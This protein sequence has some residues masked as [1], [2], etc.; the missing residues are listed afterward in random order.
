MR[1]NMVATIIIGAVIVISVGVFGVRTYRIGETFQSGQQ[2]YTESAIML[3]ESLQQSIYRLMQRG[4]N[5]TAE[6]DAGELWW[7]NAATPPDL[8]EVNRS[9]T[10]LANE[11]LTSLLETLERAGVSASEP[12]IVFDFEDD[13]ASL[14][15]DTVTFNITEFI[16][17]IEDEESTQSR[18]LARTYTYSYRTWE[19]LKGLDAW[20]RTDAGELSRELDRVLNEGKSCL[21]DSCCCFGS[22]QEPNAQELINPN[23]ASPAQINA[24]VQH[25]IDRLNDL[26][27]EGIT[28]RATHTLSP[29]YAVRQHTVAGVC[30]TPWAS[31]CAVRA[32]DNPTVL[33]TAS[34]PYAS[35]CADRRVIDP[36]ITND[37][38]N[39]ISSDS[40]NLDSSSSG[41]GGS[42]VVYNRYAVDKQLSGEIEVRCTDERASVYIDGD[43]RALE[44]VIRLG[45]AVHSEC[46]I[47]AS[48]GSTHN[49]GDSVCTVEGGASGG[50]AE[51]IECT[52][53]CEPLPSQDFCDA[54]GRIWTGVCDSNGEWTG[55]C[56]WRSCNELDCTA[57]VQCCDD[58]I[59][60]RGISCFDDVCQP[61]ESE[62]QTCED[63]YRDNYDEDE[64]DENGIPLICIPEPE[65]PAPDPNGN[66]NNGDNGQ[67]GGN[68]ENGDGP[69][70]QD[71]G[72]D[73]DPE[74][75]PAPNPPPCTINNPSADDCVPPQGVWD[76]NCYGTASC[77]DNQCFFEAIN[78]GQS[79]GD[80][81]T[82]C[83]NFVC[84]DRRCVATDIQTTTTQCGP[85][86]PSGGGL[87]KKLIYR[88]TSSGTCQ[89]EPVADPEGTCPTSSSGCECECV[90]ENPRYI[91]SCQDGFCGET[92]SGTCMEHSGTCDIS[93]A[94]AGL[95]CCSSTICGSGEICCDSTWCA[96]S[97]QCGS[98]PVGQD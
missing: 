3:E 12:V 69:G 66:G 46:S 76:S 88:C 18:N 80:G 55:D 53:M 90:N 67:N 61:I 87:C 38:T 33:M 17:R 95:V 98:D 1:G 86:N 85:D 24:A 65:P 28:C 96:T 8:D 44:A 22:G 58:T 56:A 81:E 62:Q 34:G 52:H 50:G 89:S 83:A 78:E 23:R 92:F 94:T 21:Y 13:I 45:V 42:D 37:P 57:P 25:T 51:C 6:R 64:L 32:V 19:I 48:P 73:P 29:D 41:S 36:P 77:V 16:V 15:D 31:T 10:T 59:L 2:A 72:P 97:E 60:D 26:M 5:N 7:C 11:S 54:E 93:T 75:E 91:G 39:V 84:Q 49:Y 4:Y 79:C 47:D 9:L 43:F 14:S 70:D 71:P 27:G 20:I 68:G 40:R 30:Q 35:L 74:P 82:Q 63:Y